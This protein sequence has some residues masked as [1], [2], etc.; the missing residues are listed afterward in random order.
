METGG[1]LS[2]VQLTQVNDYK[3]VIWQNGIQS[4]LT[5]RYETP[6]WRKRKV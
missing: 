3:M 2:A 6:V 4:H 5:K 1:I